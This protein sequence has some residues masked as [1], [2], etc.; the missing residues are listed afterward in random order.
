[1]TT[2]LDDRV[3]DFLSDYT[4]GRAHD[5][6]RDLAARSEEMSTLIDIVVGGYDRS[7]RAEDRLH[8]ARARIA[9]QSAALEAMRELLNEAA[10]DAHYFGRRK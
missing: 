2:R 3:R 4:G 8:R 1:M 6:V 5:L 10:Q 7:E 9:A